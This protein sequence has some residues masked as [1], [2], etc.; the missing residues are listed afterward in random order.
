MNALCLTHT[1]RSQTP[2]PMAAQEGTESRAKRTS[3]KAQVKSIKMEI[4]AAQN[5]TKKLIGIL[6][7]EPNKKKIEH[8][9][10]RHGFFLWSGYA[11]KLGKRPKGNG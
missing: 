4:E 9:S 3:P 2:N 7:I 5:Q 8:N 10:Y 11:R 1:P 6:E